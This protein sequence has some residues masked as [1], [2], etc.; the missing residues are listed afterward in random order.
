[1][2]NPTNRLSQYRTY[3]YHQFL[4]LCSSASVASSIGSSNT[5]LSQLQH[6]ADN[7]YKVRSTPGGSY[8]T[9]VDGM[10]DAHLNITKASWKTVITPATKTADGAYTSLGPTLDGVIDVYEPNGAS[11]LEI[12]SESCRLMGVSPTLMVYALKTVFIGHPH[13]TSASPVYINSIRPMTAFAYDISA[14]FD[15]TGAKYRIQTRG[16]V[17]GTNRQQQQVFSGKGFSIDKKDNPTL[18]STMAKLQ[19][20]AN[21]AYS[22]NEKAYNKLQL[23]AG[24]E[25]KT[26][27]VP[28]LYKIVVDKAWEGDSIVMGDNEIE[29]LANVFEDPIVNLSAGAADSLTGA[30]ETVLKT[31]KT[32]MQA[33]ASKNPGEGLEQRFVYSITHSVD[34]GI[35]GI[36]IHTIHIGKKKVLTTPVGGNTGNVAA[37]LTFD[38]LFTGKN[39]DIINWDMKLKQGLALLS[40]M[41]TTNSL[42][43][44]AADRRGTKSEQVIDDTGPQS[45]GGKEITNSALYPGLPVA[46]THYS[47]MKYPVATAN[48]HN[49]LSKQAEADVFDTTIT[50]HGNPLLLDE[51][52]VNPGDVTSMST[53]TSKVGDGAQINNNWINDP[54]TVRMNVKLPVNPDQLSEGYKPFWFRGLYRIIEVEHIFKDGKFTQVL[55]LY[56]IPGSHPGMENSGEQPAASVVVENTVT[57]KGVKRDPVTN[58][59]KPISRSESLNFSEIKEIAIRIANE[60]GIDPNLVLGVI[61]QESDFQI[62]AVSFIGCCFGL[63]QLSPVAAE[64][65]GVP[66]EDLFIAEQNILAGTKYLKKQLR[67]NNGDVTKALIAYNAGP[68]RLRQHLAG[69]FT[70]LQE[71]EDYIVEVPR[72]QQQFADGSALEL[73]KEAKTAKVTPVPEIEIPNAKILKTAENETV[74]TIKARAQSSIDGAKDSIVGSIPAGSTSPTT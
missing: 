52:T 23:E 63:M 16:T 69:K 14:I 43:D 22:D 71:T 62:E 3:S 64:E 10:S 20:L 1:M 65:V 48:F 30:V 68:G 70:L 47:N 31:S 61:K 24:K 19:A 26:L 39:V 73:R 50:I 37:N 7:R 25:S 6:P 44:N 9:L 51:M 34:V 28:Q 40:M 21:S 53:R 45:S 38:Y 29:R 58:K 2:S 12:I 49:M 59:V 56:G 17:G 72:W 35:S 18:T 60:Q 36:P 33:Q 27:P 66:R 8:V 11:F 55:R 46:A 67:A 41:G 54:T 15:S 74:E 42:T 13:D 57:P 32:I 4:L 5:V